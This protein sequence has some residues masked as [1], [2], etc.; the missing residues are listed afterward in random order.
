LQLDFGEVKDEK[1]V[2]II[3]A[4]AGKPAKVRTVPLTAGRRLRV[5]EGTLAEM[6]RVDVGDDWVK[7][8]VSEPLRPGLADEVRVEIPNAVDVIVAGSA[9]AA[10][11]R[12]RD[13]TVARS[14]QEL[15]ADFLAERQIDGT[16]LTKL[17]A[18]LY[19]LVGEAAE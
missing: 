1:G 15:F 19:D 14:P 12:K 8:V 5:I 10:S 11:K 17:F 2:L 6:S 9:A 4:H 7:A 18:E 3:E 13:E 16:D